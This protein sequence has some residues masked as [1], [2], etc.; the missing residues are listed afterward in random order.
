M[1][2]WV[3]KVDLNIYPFKYAALFNKIF[4]IEIVI[5]SANA[6]EYKSNVYLAIELKNE[7]KTT[8]FVKIYK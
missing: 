2:L 6:R 4:H 5:H 8:K 1:P 7:S 3:E